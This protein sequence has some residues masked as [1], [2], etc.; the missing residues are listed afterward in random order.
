M[1]WRR[2]LLCPPPKLATH[3]IFAGTSKESFLVP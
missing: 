2:M 1:H 3:T